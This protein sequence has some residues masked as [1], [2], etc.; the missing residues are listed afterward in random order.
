[1]LMSGGTIR[2]MEGDELLTIPK[3]AAELG[4]SH[5]T[6]RRWVKAGHLRAIKPGSDY[7]IHRKAL[8]PF[9]DRGNRPQPGRPRKAD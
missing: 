2:R 4:V 8:E 9:R 5:M 7:L 3:A 1:M 6:I